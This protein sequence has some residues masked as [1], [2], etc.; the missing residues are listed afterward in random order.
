M[1]DEELNARTWP[2]ER[3]CP[4]CGRVFCVL[5]QENWRYREGDILLCSWG[6][7]RKREAR[8]EQKKESPKAR[9]ARRM[10]PKQKESIV[11]A[12]VWMGMTNREISERTGL[13]DQTVNYYRRKNEKEVGENVCDDA[14]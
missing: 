8:A 9:K 6:C 3:K 14:G 7:M 11:L 1:I 12:C 4:E 2:F 5:V 10:S 13:S